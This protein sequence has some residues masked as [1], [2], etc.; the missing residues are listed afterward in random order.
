MA[1]ATVTELE[2]LFTTDTSA[3]DKATTEVR[4]TGEK[5]EKKPVTAKVDA[6][7]KG[8]LGGMDRVEAEAKKIV[9]AKTMATVDANIERA[10]KNLTRTQERLDYL[11]S[12]ETD[13][14]VT[15]DIKRAEKALERAQRSLDGLTS[16]KTK[17]EVDADTSKAE[18]EVKEL[19]DTAAASGKDGGKR[20]GSGLVSS[21]DGATRGAGQAV[22]D[23]I[24]GDIGS[25]LESAL[26]AIPIAGG[27]IL[28]AGAIGKAIVGGIED[29]MAQEVGRDRLQALTGIDVRAA[30]RLADAAGEAYATNFGESIE[31]NMDT[32]R[33][34][35]QFDL[36]DESAT[37][38]S[39]T[40]VIAGLAGIADVL[41]EDVQPI[42]TAVTTLLKTG[43]AK[44][45]EDA[46]DI[47]ATG[48]REGV[49]RGDDLL[50]TFTEYPAVLKRLGLNGS[51]MLGLLN[52]SLDAGARNSDV[53]AD[54]LKEFQIRA[55]D[56]SKSSSEAFKLL[57]M[58]AEKMTAK[59][60]E[61]GDGAREGLE[62]V[63]TG[64]RDME[65][66]VARNTAAVGLFGTKAE[67]LGDALFA[68][69]LSTA[70]DE[71]NGVTGAAQR[72][73]DTMADNDASKMEEAQ[74]NIEVAADGIKGALAT[75]FS[76]PLGD[77][78]EWVSSNR[79]PL[80]QFF[81]DMVNG[82]IDFGIAA[83]TA[84]G[85]FVSGP[86]AS[87]IEGLTAAVDYINGPFSG[88][89]EE[90]VTLSES[91]RGFSDTTDGANTKLE[92]MR[93]EFNR[94]ADAQVQL[95]YVHDAA[96]RTATAIGQVGVN[97]DGSSMALGGLDV[98]NLDATASGRKLDTQVRDAIASLDEQIATAAAAGE[99]QGDLAGRYMDATGA[100]KDQLQ[101][102]GM[103]EEQAQALIDTYMGV[104]GVRSTLVSAP[105]ATAAKDH[106]DEL[107]QEIAK[108]PPEKQTEINALLDQGDVTAVEKALNWAARTRTADIRAQI[109]S[110]VDVRTNVIAKADGGLVEFMAA[111][112]LRSMQP[113]AQ[114]VP[115]NTWR[116]V[117]DRSD[118]DEAYIP[119]DGS[120]R[121]MA[122]LAETMR[123]MGI[124]PMAQGAVASSG[125]SAPVAL[126]LSDADVSRIAA[127]VRVGSEAGTAAGISA[128]DASS[129]RTL[130]RL[131]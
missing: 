89:P 129:A 38:R 120:P 121:S 52:Q 117:G 128:R 2:V 6:D 130:G 92:E 96:Q 62:Q 58:N 13:L 94:F 51:E 82:A 49:N 63:L 105:G 88:A 79:G 45:A 131:R 59:I 61:G 103:T 67:D 46:F 72:M 76:E 124:A 31:A 78:A 75:A 69:D 19:A 84:I 126:T 21:L 8:A 32:A 53:A 23:A 42:A 44:S 100:L 35:L 108:L 27:I 10:E 125:S 113:V 26:Q 81:Q 118:V 3:V 40:K 66:P 93:G 5:I 11:R 50:D 77:L 68:M 34:A 80:L 39:S 112:G 83:N 99:G 60:A 119:L 14:E 73:F 65:D 122:I 116:V 127:A 74:R 1:K 86:L 57:G 85:D 12:V 29:G 47:L 56:G 64:L 18:S 41:E 106:V 95:G 55:T 15:A 22:G 110:G 17:L 98:A 36:I 48:A 20:A 9:S 115:P 37:T 33:I 43:M 54:A 102:M 104:P 4:K 16:A 70:V 109:R 123:R 30:Q 71:L 91:M 111:G 114:M 25:S 101:A 24:G 28:A 87:M 7:V 107:R 90:L 97:A